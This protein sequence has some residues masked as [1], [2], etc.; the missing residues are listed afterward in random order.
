MSEKKSCTI[1]VDLLPGRLQVIAGSVVFSASA[2]PGFLD[3]LSFSK[4]VN[5]VSGPR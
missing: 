2:E 4:L 5:C 1:P 3:C